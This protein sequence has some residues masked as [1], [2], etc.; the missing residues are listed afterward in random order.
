M[1]GEK[2][3]KNINEDRDRRR[4]WKKHL[5]N[6]IKYSWLSYLDLHYLDYNCGTD[7]PGIVLVYK[8]GTIECWDH[9]EGGTGF[10][11][12]LYKDGRPYGL[13]KIENSELEETIEDYISR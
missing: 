3:I 8:D 10:W 11:R 13:M 2:S 1:E 5:Y 12:Y 4:K 7:G 6:M 9:N